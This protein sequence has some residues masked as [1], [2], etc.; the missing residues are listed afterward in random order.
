MSH[1]KPL[2]IVNYEV[3]GERWVRRAMRLPKDKQ[4]INRDDYGLMV[5]LVK[6]GDDHAK[7]TRGI[8]VYVEVK[9][10]VGWLIEFET[11]RAGIE[12]LSTS[13][14]MHNEL[15]SLRGDELAEQKQ[16]DLSDK[17]YTRIMTISY[18]ALRNIY[19]A[20]RTHRHPDWW[21]FCRW[22][23]TLPLFKMVI[24]P[25]WSDG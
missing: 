24:Y 11:Y 2:D 4:P 15:M 14:S 8:I 22:I 10:Q 7:C 17:V 20:R 1:Y 6:A 16:K 25:E 18:Q 19:K 5:K 21:I 23:E 3:V 9:F 13:S 12:C